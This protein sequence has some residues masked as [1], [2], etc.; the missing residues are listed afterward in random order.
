M[1]LASKERR[2][3]QALSSTFTRRASNI[4]SC[5]S[6][7]LSASTMKNSIYMVLSTLLRQDRLQSC[8]KSAK[9]KDVRQ[10][11]KS[12]ISSKANSCCFCRTRYVSNPTSLG[13]MRSSLN[14]WLLGSRLTLKMLWPCHTR[15]LLQIYRSRIACSILTTWLSRILNY[16]GQ[17]RW[18]P[19][20]IGMTAM[21]QWKYRSRWI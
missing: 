5:I 7:N 21:L 3:H 8:W 17:N 11:L 1:S 4:W 10:K 16:L 12:W 13:S 15:W 18:L 19:G 6:A 14:Q 9:E 20:R 2:V